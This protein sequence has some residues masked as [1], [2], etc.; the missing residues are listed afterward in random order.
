M[1]AASDP[2]RCAQLPPSR[3]FLHK[4]VRIS[5]CSVQLCV[6]A[7]ALMIRSELQPSCSLLKV[8]VWP[9]GPAARWLHGQLGL[10]ILGCEAG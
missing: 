4:C 2:S 9:P 3:P 8:L 1:A 7:A 6:L 5:S 10:Q